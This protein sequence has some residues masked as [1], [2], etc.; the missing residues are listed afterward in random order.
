[1][2]NEWETILTTL[3]KI[4]VYKK[5]A[6]EESDN[7][8]ILTHPEHYR[9]LILRYYSLQ[10]D[11]FQKQEIQISDT[12]AMNTLSDILTD[13]P[14]LQRRRA[15][16]RNLVMERIKDMKWTKS[17]RAYHIKTILPLEKKQGRLHLYQDILE[18]IQRYYKSLLDTNQIF[19]TY[20]HML[21]LNKSNDD[22][23]TRTQ[24]LIQQ[25][26]ET[27]EHLEVRDEALWHNIMR[28]TELVETLHTSTI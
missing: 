17:Q 18:V 24:T 8:G 21:F 10:L 28:L 20:Q 22:E 25:A 16:A 3:I 6:Y 1:M 13:L 26:N 14:E 2:E 5:K 12:D 23:M 15:V 27:Q 9:D 19:Q 11:L 7:Q 4:Y